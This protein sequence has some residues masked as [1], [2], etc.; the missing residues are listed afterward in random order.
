MARP[1]KEPRVNLRFKDHNDLD[2]YELIALRRGMSLPAWIKATMHR[3][4]EK[5]SEPSIS[6]KSILIIRKHIEDGASRE[7]VQKA[8]SHV[9]SYLEDI[10]SYAS[11]KH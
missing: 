9:K 3:E 5:D 8:K 1:R 10:K 4:L 11:H 6:E 2:E 7:A